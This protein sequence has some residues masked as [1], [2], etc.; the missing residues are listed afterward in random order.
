L[1]A[2]GDT[3]PFHDGIARIVTRDE[4]KRIPAWRRTFAGHPKDHRFY[5]LIDGTLANEFEHYY[6]VLDD[7]TGR[8]RG[9]QPVFFVRQNLAEG[10]PALLGA[11]AAVRRVF[12]RFL[13]TR[14]LMVGCAAGRGHLGVCE[15]GD[16]E[17]LTIALLATLET[18]ARRRGASLIV[19]KDFPAH[20]RETME[21]LT[22]NGYTRVPSMPMTTLPLGYGAFEEYL[23]TLG[24]A[25]RKNLRRKFRKIDKAAPLELQV[26]QDV[27]PYLDELYP[28][29]QQVYERSP[30][31]F[32]RLTKD[33]FRGLGAAMPEKVRF[34]MWRQDG[35]AVAFSLCLVHDGTIYDD[36]LG[37]EYP[38]AL[39]LHLYFQTLRDIIRWSLAQGVE[40]YCSSP[41]NYAPKL[42][43]GCE[44]MPLDLYA[45]HTSK[46][47]NPLF[48]RALEFLE[49]TR[50][51]PVLRE[52]P[53]AADLR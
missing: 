25:T 51:D 1:P 39:D 41:L 26:T 42:H 20:Y 16:E 2:A 3:I 24:K 53:N 13:T 40:R 35:R 29:Y 27:T 43:L 18:F 22:A 33:Y 8:T 19:F 37:L 23:N 52:F 30:L 47:I 32:E 36:Y 49:P 45:M 21:R 28:L 5:E 9:I 44:L 6:L 34:F 15:P 50:H 38:L 17:W 48:R 31:K 4:L 7:H 12:P 14:V 10:V 11:V 46:L